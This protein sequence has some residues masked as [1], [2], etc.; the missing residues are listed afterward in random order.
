M[1]VAP[2]SMRVASSFAV[3][4]GITGKLIIDLIDVGLGFGVGLS[5]FVSFG[6]G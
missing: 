2:G 4:T 6:I 1:L 5:G 3:V